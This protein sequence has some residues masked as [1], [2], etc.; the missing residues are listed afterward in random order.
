MMRRL[1]YV[2]SFPSEAERLTVCIYITYNNCDLKMAV[3]ISMVDNET[4][5]VDWSV[6]MVKFQ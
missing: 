4:E 6:N 5:L 3:K 2:D 1:R